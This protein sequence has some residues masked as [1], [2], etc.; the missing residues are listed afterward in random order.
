MHLF[1]S[2]SLATVSLLLILSLQA[3][4]NPE[5]VFKTNIRSVRFH[6]NGDQLALPVYKLNSGDRLE[7]HFDDMDA[8]VKSYYYTYQLCDYDWQPVQLSPFDYIKGFTQTRIT[9][10]RYSSIA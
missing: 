10:Y 3:Q 8:N 6:V 4:K 1:K 7:L 2:F 9:N 5:A